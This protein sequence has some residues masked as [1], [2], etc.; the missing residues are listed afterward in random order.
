MMKKIIIKILTKILSNLNINNSLLGK[1]M[2]SI[3]KMNKNK[4]KY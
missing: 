1:I 4:L 2:M 3:G